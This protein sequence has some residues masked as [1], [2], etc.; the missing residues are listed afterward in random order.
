MNH[1]TDS[2]IIRLAGLGTQPAKERAAG[3]LP[4]DP[5]KEH[6]AGCPACEARLRK[7]RQV[8]RA[9]HSLPE[10]QVSPG[11]ARSVLKAAGIQESSSFLWIAMKALSPVIG[12]AMV[13]AAIVWLPGLFGWGEAAPASEISGEISDRL[14]GIS[15]QAETIVGQGLAWFSGLGGSFFS[16][17]AGSLII[18]LAALFGVASLLDKFFLEPALRRRR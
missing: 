11:F 13:A 15:A 17:G 18:Y 14:A 4:F 2:E 16:G 3:G 10:A 7:A 12:I 5:S 6:L 1:L 9:L 8:E